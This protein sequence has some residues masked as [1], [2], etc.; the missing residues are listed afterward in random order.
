MTTFVRWKVKQ[1]GKQG[2][3]IMRVSCSKWYWRLFHYIFRIKW[4]F[5]V[6]DVRDMYYDVLGIPKHPDQLTVKEEVD[7]VTADSHIS[8]DVPE[9]ILKVERVFELMK[10]KGMA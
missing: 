10:R 9:D 8:V 5:T 2:I 6:D 3:L 1:P 7:R 4:A